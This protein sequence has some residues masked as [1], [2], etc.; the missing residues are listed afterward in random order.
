MVCVTKV[1]KAALEKALAENDGPHLPTVSDAPADLVQP[2]VIKID[3]S[4]DAHE[5]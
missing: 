5:M 3:P 1:A 2:L 4:V